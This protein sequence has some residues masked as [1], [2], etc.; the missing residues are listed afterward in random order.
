LK[1][2]ITAILKYLLYKGIFSTTLPL[3][4]Y[5]LFKKNSKEKS[6]RVILFYILYCIFNEALSF[7]LQSIHSETFLILLYS[8]TILEF[9]F[10]SLFIFVI[11][12]DSVVKQIIPYLWLSF[13]IF[14]FI[15][16]VFV[17]KGR[18]FDSI[19]M[20]IECILVLSMCISYLFLILRKSNNLFIYST[21]EFWVVIT[22]LIYFSGTFFL[23]I[24]AESMRDN[25]AFRKQYFIIN[26][27]FN[28][29]KNLLLSIAMT[30]KLSNTVKQ[31]KNTLPDLDDDFF[32]SEN[33]NFPN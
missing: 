20:G 13:I 2:N 17:N 24:L 21:F 22:F 32:I 12:P 9:S 7:Y 11:I 14:Y 5:L 4:F 31:Q 26:I 8:F 23:Y 15:D 25:L 27:S 29:L 18:G 30:M 1:E 19:A 28:L 33:V 6:L 10:F 3:V 16:L